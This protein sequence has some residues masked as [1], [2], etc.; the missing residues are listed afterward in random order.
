LKKQEMRFSLVVSVIGPGVYGAIK[1]R[2]EAA[3]SIPVEI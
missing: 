1:P 3:A 2:V